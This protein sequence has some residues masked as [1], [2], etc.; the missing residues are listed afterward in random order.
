VS[1]TITITGAPKNFEPAFEGAG[2]CPAPTTSLCADPTYTLSDQTYTLPLPAGTWDMAG[3]YELSGFGGVFLSPFAAVTVSAGQ[4]TTQNF[5]I[6]YEKPATFHG[7][8]QVTGLP[9]AVSIEE[10]SA[11]LCPSFAPWNGTSPPSI[12]CVTLDSETLGSHSVK[13]NTLPPGSWLAYPGYC[14]EFG[15]EEN[16]AA[17]QSITL[18]SGRPTRAVLTTP[19]ILPGEGLVSG[20]VTVS[21]APVGFSDPV[22]FVACPTGTTDN[23]QTYTAEPEG[24]SYDILLPVGGWTLTSLYL[25]EPFDN[26]VL[27][28]AVDVTVSGGEDTTADLVVSY[29]VPAA[30]AGSISVTGVP[31]G[32]PIEDYTVLACPASTGTGGLGYLTCVEEESGKGGSEEEPIGVASVD[33]VAGAARMA[34]AKLA[35]HDATTGVGKPDSYD[36]PTLT[37]GSWVLYPG[38]VTA[39]GSY[40]DPTGTTVNAPSGG[41]VHQNLTVPYQAPT[42]GLVTGSVTVTGAPESGYEAIVEACSAPPTELSCDNEEGTNVED[43]GDYQL[44]LSAGTWWVAAVVFSFESGQEVVGSPREVVV[45]AGARSRAN[46]A[47]AFS[48]S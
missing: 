27:G 38:Y 14:T 6:A 10:V 2:A 18:T 16:A 24:S 12:A 5:T 17:V 32:V 33:R 19:F 31:K 26:A 13:S 4:T 3:F 15:C 44:P 7:S 29:Q 21:G 40:Q 46:L 47:V 39:Y 25:A 22:G 28:P 45:T 42:D 20:T 41:I 35:R 36:L 9:K 11:L 1:G 23:C 37:G 8:I 30:A 34:A 48:S 43:N